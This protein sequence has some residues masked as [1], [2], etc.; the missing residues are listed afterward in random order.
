M[1]ARHMRVQL[2]ALYTN[3]ESHSAQRHRQTD[4]NS[5]CVRDRPSAGVPV[6]HTHWAESDDADDKT[7]KNATYA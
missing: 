5:V 6:T 3:P 2:L 7:S 1:P 4:K